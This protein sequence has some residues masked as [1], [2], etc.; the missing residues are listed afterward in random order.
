MSNLVLTGSWSLQ[1]TGW[2]AGNQPGQNQLRKK[3]TSLVKT[4]SIKV[5][6]K[7]SSSLLL[8]PS[9]FPSHWGAGP[10][11]T[12]PSPGEN[13]GTET[14]SCQRHREAFRDDRMEVQEAGIQVKRAQCSRGDHD[15][16]KTLK[17][18]LYCQGCIQTAQLPQQYSMKKIRALA[19]CPSIHTKTQP[20]TLPLRCEG[21]SI[22][23]EKE[24]LQ[25]RF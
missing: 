7:C 9:T 3:R 25:N 4:S 22:S 20:T 19:L 10:H 13:H 5:Q 12:L 2:K 1:W 18:W 6:I 14:V 16:L 17:D 8:A 21:A 15:S 24:L 23:T 11:D